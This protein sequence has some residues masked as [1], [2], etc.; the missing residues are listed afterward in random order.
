MLMATLHGCRVYGAVSTWSLRWHWIHHWL[1]WA[2]GWSCLPPWP[3]TIEI[4]QNGV[5]NASF[6]VMHVFMTYLPI[7]KNPYSARLK[8]CRVPSRINLSSTLSC[9]ANVLRCSRTRNYW[10]YQCSLVLDRGM[11][12]WFLG[13]RTR[14]DS[15]RLEARAWSHAT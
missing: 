4:G 12:E 2:G 7:R 13:N 1:G 10:T 14:R 11:L 15:S 6:L 5:V 3:A 9:C 8:S